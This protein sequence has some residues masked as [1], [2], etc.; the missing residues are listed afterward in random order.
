MALPEPPG[1]VTDLLGEIRNGNKGAED[2][3]IPLVYDE[4]R[5]LARRYLKRER[6]NH[7]LQTTALVNEAYLRLSKNNAA[8]AGALDKAHFFAIS[9]TLMRRILVDHARSRL[10]QKRGGDMAPVE[11]DANLGGKAQ[12]FDSLLCVNQALTRLAEVDARQAR[13]VELRFFAGLEIEEIAELLDVSSRTIKRDWQFAQAWLYAE[14][15]VPPAKAASMSP[16][17]KESR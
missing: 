9:A 13:V 1:R 14:M 11:L 5:R 4:L 7:T 15:F 6:P 8:G 12:S 16:V 2:A 17:A 3:L 10:S